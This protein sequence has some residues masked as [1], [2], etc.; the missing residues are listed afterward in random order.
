MKKNKSVIVFLIIISVLTTIGV[1]F[2]LQIYLRDYD[3]EYFKIQYDTTWKVIDN[4]DKLILKHKAS[5]S[6]LNI[7]VKLLEKNFINIKLSDI[8]NDVIYSV[9]EQNKEYNLINVVD[10]PNDKYE[11]YSYLYEK[12]NEQVLVNI[13]KENTLL[14]IAF[15]QADSEYYDIVLD[16]VDTI[17]NSLEL[18]SREKP[19][20]SP[21]NNRF[22][23][24]TGFFDSSDTLVKIL[25]KTYL[26]AHP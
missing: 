16:S 1:A 25:Y 24:M 13:Y 21:R 22:F 12:D 15:Y 26:W 3:N 11:S 17:L 20:S 18:Y 19:G 14:V 4:K 23:K 8:I 10:N 7:Q 5:D 2:S 9:E 6:I